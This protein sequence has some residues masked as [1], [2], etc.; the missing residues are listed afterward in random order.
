MTTIRMDY[1][2][3][4]TYL[5]HARQPEYLEQVFRQLAEFARAHT[6]DDIDSLVMAGQF[7]TRFPQPEEIPLRGT[8]GIWGD[9]PAATPGDV[10]NAILGQEPGG[11][12]KT[13]RSPRRTRK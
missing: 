12:V 10:R 6:V 13:N 3:H 11:P 1:I 4:M 2:E 5:S 8:L 9:R 7:Q